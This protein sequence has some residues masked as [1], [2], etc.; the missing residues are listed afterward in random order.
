[1]MPQKKQMLAKS[2]RMGGQSPGFAE[3]S[4]SPLN[5]GTGKALHSCARGTSSA[6]SLRY[7]T[8]GSVGGA[9]GKEALG[10]TYPDAFHEDS[11]IVHAIFQLDRS[12]YGDAQK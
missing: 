12:Y 8:T 1:M 4:G 11:D 2:F 10:S 3:L 6:F 7:D 5:S 9:A